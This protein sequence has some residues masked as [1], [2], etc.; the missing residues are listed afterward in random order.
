MED[1]QHVRVCVFKG[2]REKEREIIKNLY[3]DFVK[4]PKWIHHF[5]VK[6]EKLEASTKVAKHD[7]F[8][9]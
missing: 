7:L 9:S 3:Y 8:P 4:Q 6:M 5:L 1:G 2:K